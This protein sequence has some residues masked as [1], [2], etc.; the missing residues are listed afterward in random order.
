M[1]EYDHRRNRWAQN[2]RGQYYVDRQCLDC[3]MCRE[4]APTVFAR[5][6]KR[7]F[8]Y[9]AKQPETAEELAHATEA[10]SSC[11]QEAIHDDGLVFNWDKISSIDYH[12]AV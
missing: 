3:N 2:V 9:V 8:S 5:N 1:K 12:N 11:P 7:G 4:F 10:V 6:H